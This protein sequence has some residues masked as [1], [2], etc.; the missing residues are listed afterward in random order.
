MTLYLKT[1]IPFQPRTD[2]SSGAISS[3]SRQEWLVFGRMSGIQPTPGQNGRIPP[4][5]PG[6]SPSCPQLSD[7]G[8]MSGIRAIHGCLSGSGPSP[9][10]TVRPRPYVR[11]PGQPRPERPAGHDLALPRL[12]AWLGSWSSPRLFG[13]LGFRWVGEL[14][15]RWSWPVC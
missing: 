12:E 8:C 11:D 1:K 5:C 3:S 15:F 13:V 14:G 7:P 9:A 4:V 10:T 6:S 2:H